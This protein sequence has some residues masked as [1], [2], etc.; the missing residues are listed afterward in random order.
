MKIEPPWEESRDSMY[1][2]I[3]EENEMKRGRKRG[4]DSRVG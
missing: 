4:E 2:R 1:L 3:E